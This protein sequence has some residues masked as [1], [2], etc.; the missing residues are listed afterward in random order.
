M[1]FFYI[2]LAHLVS[3]YLLQPDNLVE[4]KKH[5]KWGLFMHS[6][7]HFLF[8]TLILFLYTGQPG[9]AMLAF[10]MALSHFMIDYAKAA[11]D[12]RKDNTAMYYWLDQLAHYLSAGL[13]TVIAWQFGEL[14]ARRTI[15]F[16]NYFDLLFFNPIFVTYGCLVIFMTLT[17]E[18]SHF[19][20]RS[21]AA[22][23]PVLNKRNM[24]KRL[25]LATIIYLGLSFALV[26]SVGLNF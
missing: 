13:V 15:D 5:S 22:D 20:Y 11:H 23:R 16:G 21:K 2:L 3:D 26:P 10:L 25:L 1:I 14:F 7:I 9:V 6:F 18:Y 4:W 12:L 19:K 24:I 8:T 17:I